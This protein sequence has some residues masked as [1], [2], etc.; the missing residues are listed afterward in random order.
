MYKKS[1]TYRKTKDLPK[2]NNPEKIILHHTG[3]TNA[4]PLADTSHH[5]AEIVENWHLAKGWLGIGYH[6]FI[7]KTGLLCMDEPSKFRG[8]IRLVRI[9]LL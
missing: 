1:N 2:V 5:T 9:L 3:G 8:R 7:E 4:N 6:F